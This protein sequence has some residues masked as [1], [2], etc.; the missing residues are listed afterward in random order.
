MLFL[1]PFQSYLEDNS[2]SKMFYKVIDHF[3]ET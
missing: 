2:D 3:K 1:K